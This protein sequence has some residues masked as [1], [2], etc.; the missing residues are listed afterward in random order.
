MN[1]M[2]GFAALLG[3]ITL[4]APRAEAG[5]FNH[6]GSGGHNNGGYSNAGRGNNSNNGHDHSVAPVQAFHGG[7]RGGHEGYRGNE[8]YRGH[9]GYNG[10]GYRGDY[11]RPNYGRSIDP[12]YYAHDRYSGPHYDAWRGGRWSH[13]TWGGRYGWFWVAGGAYTYYAAPV[14][15]YPAYVEPVYTATAVEPWYFCQSANAYY[16]YVSACPEGWLQVAPR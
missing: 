4:S 6:G 8:G 12:G 3:G 11:G 5:G 14:Y 9:E 10:N 16:P 2:V 7:E 1:W 13:Q 15:P